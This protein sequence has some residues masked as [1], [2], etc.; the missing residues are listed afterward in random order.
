MSDDQIQQL[1]ELI[2]EADEETVAAAIDG[3]YVEDVLHG[4]APD[5]LLEF[6]GL[7]LDQLI[8]KEET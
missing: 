7:M 2:A 4:I 5:V 3:H 1:R 6:F 8:G